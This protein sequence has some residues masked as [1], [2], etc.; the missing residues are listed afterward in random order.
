MIGPARGPVTV[1]GFLLSPF[2]RATWYATGAG[3]L[4]LVVG[5]AAGAVVYS[6]LSAGLS[7]L[8]VVIGVPFIAVG[9]EASRL[10][11]RIERRRAFAGEATIPPAHPYRPLRGTFADILRA[12]FADENRWRDVLYVAVNLPLSIIEFVAVFV[13]WTVALTLITAPLWYD[14]L[15]GLA[16]PIALVPISMAVGLLLVPAAASMS[17]IIIALHRGVVA[18]L[19]CT[20]PERELRRQVETLKRS[21]AALLEVEQSELHRIER[22]LHDGTQQRLV[23]LA[24]DLA[25]ASERIDADP[26]AAKELI[27]QGSTQ[28]RQ[29]LAEIRDLVRGI[30]PSILLDRGLMPAIESISGHGPVPTTMVT[31]LEPGQRLPLA[32]ERTAYFVVAESLA[33]VGKHSGATRCEVRVRHEGD[34]LVVETWDDGRGAAEVGPGGGLAGLVGRLEGVDGS[35]SV[36]SPPGGPTLIRAKIPIG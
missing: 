8:L 21:R 13:P 18:G 2:D 31:D 10:A 9:I 35:L 11:A 20:S 16:V 17:Q 22:D 4:G 15:P 30:A 1:R 36:S 28:A 12:E 34:R 32:V 33:N 27:A 19:L 25:L 6:A 5:V 7:T 23:A 14:F 29:A 26:A 3:A 24:I